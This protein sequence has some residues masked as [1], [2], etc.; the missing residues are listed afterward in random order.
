MMNNP[1][2]ILD[3]SLPLTPSLFQKIREREFS[4]ALN[5]DGLARIREKASRERDLREFYR[6]RAPYELLQNASDAGATEACYILTFGGVVFAHNGNWF[7]GQNFTSLAH[8]WSDKD[9]NECIGHKGIGFRSVLDITPAPHIVR[10]APD[11]FFGVKFSW[12]HN[13]G[14]M[15]KIFAADHFAKHEY[16]KWAKHDDNFC[17]IMFIPGT[18]KK[19]DI[20]PA[21]TIFEN[22]IQD[23]FGTNL[24][25]MFWFP[26]TDDGL[27]KKVL[28]E[29]SPSPLSNNEFGRNHLLDFLEEQVSTLIQFLVSMREV[30]LYDN[31][32]LIGRV[33][34]EEQTH[35]LKANE[36]LVTT[37]TLRDK[38]EKRYF[39]QH[40]TIKIPSHIKGHPST[41][42]ALKS[43]DEAKLTLSVLLKNNQPVPDFDAVFHVYFP[44][45]AQT[46]LGYVVH[47]DFHVEPNRKRLMDC[48]PGGYNDWLLDQAAHLAANTLL[49]NL[50]DH[51]N[52]LHVFEALAPT[53]R[54]FDETSFPSRFSKALKKR[55][56]PFIPSR[57]GLL[58]RDEILIPPRVDSEAFWETNFADALETIA[59]DKHAFLH[60]ESDGP[61]TRQ[62]LNLAGTDTIK[63]EQLFNFIENVPEEFQDADWWYECYTYMAEDEELSQMDPESFLGR[64]LLPTNSQS[65]A[66]VPKNENIIVTLPPS[67]KGVSISVPPLLSNLFVFLDSELAQLLREGNEKVWE[68]VR[69]H[70]QIS[71]FEASERLQRAVLILA[72]Q[73]FRGKLQVQLQD[74]LECWTFF[75]KTV[76]ASR[77]S[78]TL[79][80]ENIGRFPVPCCSVEKNKSLAPQSLA[81]AFLTYWPPTHRSPKSPLS[82]IPNLRC[83]DTKFLK[84]LEEESGW[85]SQEIQT[86]F[87]RVG[88]SDMPK[89]LHYRRIVTAP[90]IALSEDGVETYLQT[91]FSG[92]RQRDENLAVAA[93]LL[94]DECWKKLVSEHSSQYSGTL[95][96]Q[97]LHLI[98]GLKI[99]S[100]VAI[101][102]FNKNNEKWE[103]RLDRLTQSILEAIDDDLPT[104]S[105]FRRQ[106]VGGL[107][108]P[109]QSFLH[110]QL[111]THPFLPS[112]KGPASLETCFL[113]LH[114]RRLISIGTSQRELGDL[115]LPYV[116]VDDHSKLAQLENLGVE[117][118]EDAS[119]ASSIAL[120]RAL[121]ELGE[122]LTSEWGQNEIVKNRPLWRLVRGAIQEIYR[123]L[124]QKDEDLEFIPNTRFVTRVDRD[125]IFTSGHLYYAE[126]GS[127]MERAFKKKLPLFDADRVYLQLFKQIGI[128]QLVPNKTVE[129]KFL[130]EK[131]AKLADSL[132]NEIVDELAPYL[133]SAISA[134][135]ELPPNR[136]NIVTRLK[137]RFKV[138]TIDTL[139]ISFYLSED[140]SIE[141]TIEFPHFYLQRR[142][143]NEPVPGT[144]HFT[145][146]VAGNGNEKIR[147]LDCDAL[148]EDL[149]P[150]FLLDEAN[151][152]LRSLFPRI[153][154][155]Y[156]HEYSQADKMRDFMLH[157]L[158]VSI[159]LQDTEAARIRGE[160]KDEPPPPPPPPTVVQP[161][162]VNTDQEDD[163]KQRHEEELNEE[164]KKI[165]VIVTG[166][167]SNGP[168]TDDGESPPEGSGEPTPEQQSRGTR[169]E[170]EIK[171]RTSRVGGWADFTF[172]DDLRDSGVGFDFLCQKNG[173]DVKVEV[174][175]FKPN[176]RIF[177]TQRE[178]QVAAANQDEYYCIGLLDEGNSP[179]KWRSFE[180]QN[181]IRTLMEVGSFRLT[182]SLSANASEIFEFG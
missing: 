12:S 106:Q 130:G 67:E 104:D 129:E 177:F 163:E 37:D 119:S 171:R 120:T 91:P 80:W 107:P 174:K 141:R 150:V 169:G 68:W 180:L 64:K 136:D 18:V 165:K 102:E 115:L 176:G 36:I 46:G 13:F 11:D 151:N 87:E 153:V 41:P 32:E 170:L 131:N 34:S 6:K 137:E 16:E 81:P 39:R 113:R 35:N 139:H 57:V 43:L 126:P 22:I 3:K 42:K 83:I 79:F 147:D 135:S 88:V 159:D 47:G 77:I 31:R 10:I 144:A 8:G 59:P 96:L 28:E 15:Q 154:S 160:L 72:P 58:R 158:G 2:S 123:V 143:E 90:P 65:I 117:I 105:V 155:R 74:L 149:I 156:Q 9:P 92:E 24:T 19:L 99:C 71:S 49:T 118:L 69:T 175:T 51:Y 40:T 168:E 76:G 89:L 30:R 21:T 148:G 66:K 52:P 7:T 44:T 27:Q 152:E 179:E 166:Q 128:T 125:F 29:L 84:L 85:T 20:G 100:A 124:N 56:K 182:S 178:L 93:N 53:N 111:S 122:Q 33:R 116:V 161:P 145:L 95:E 173:Q 94:Q 50:L 103:E 114:N 172:R 55:E 23:H 97:S 138:K 60:P 78:E 132:R 61:K 54:L 1:V 133:L 134:K 62:F 17:P 110:R 75:K 25:T 112:T 38:I 142:N 63:S 109:I 108:I 5:F 157:Q 181:P 101:E 82:D 121:F 70:F 98:D 4:P 146:F 167:P 127:A 14:Y 164:M 73:I 140:P 45:E 86:W 48:T 26:A 162:P